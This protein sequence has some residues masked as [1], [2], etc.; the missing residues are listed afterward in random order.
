MDQL[1]QDLKAH[2]EE[3]I[4]QQRNVVFKYTAPFI[5]PQL[6]DSKTVLLEYEK[7]LSLT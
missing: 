3:N 1:L 5:S 7:K 2:I 6:E 4:V